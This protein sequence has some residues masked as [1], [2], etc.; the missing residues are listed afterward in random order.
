MTLSLY[1]INRF[2]QNLVK[3]QVGIFS[4]LFLITATE[5]LAFLANKK[6]DLTTTL[7][8]IGTRMPEQLALT[9]PLVIL[10]GSLFTFL[11]LSRSSE[12]VVMRASGISAFRMLIPPMIMAIILG[13]MASAIFN[14]VVAATIRKHSEL[15]DSFSKSR[16]NQLSLSEDGIWLRQA[17]ESSFF[18]I[19]ARNLSGDGVILFNVR[20]HEFTPDGRLVRRIEAQRA[21]LMEDEWRLTQATQW[22]FLDRNLDDRSDIRPF[23]V[24]YLPTKLSSEDILESFTPPERMSI[25]K[26][27]AFI[28]QLEASG[29][30]SVRHRLFLQSKLSEPLLLAA[31]VLVGAVFAFRP[32][33]FGNAGLMALLAVLSGFLLYAL[34]NIAESLGEAQAIPIGLAAWAP[35]IAATL[36]AFAL[37]LHLEDG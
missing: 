1:I 6:S 35:A 25:W 36:F 24:L 19:Q 14:P 33:R 15:R 29:F 23:D 18:V 37:L 21:Q 3:V 30:T 27:P 16:Q 10:L 4:L 22:R 5:E 13:A 31:M 28:V 2:F 32:S 7:A 34:K 12:L 20:F 11:G 9:F 8:L 26:I 17:N